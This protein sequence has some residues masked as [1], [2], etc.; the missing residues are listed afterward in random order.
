M[1]VSPRI[2]R[3]TGRPYNFNVVYVPE[4]LIPM[5]D[6]LLRNLKLTSKDEEEDQ[7]PLPILAVNYITGNYQQHPDK[8]VMAWIREEPSKKCHI[9]IVDKV[10]EKWNCSLTGIIK[11]N[12]PWRTESF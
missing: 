10:H 4:K 7:I 11:M 5:T 6:A 12:F 1:D 3:L 2:Q 9:T 8:P